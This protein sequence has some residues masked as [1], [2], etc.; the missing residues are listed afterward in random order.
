MF[1]HSECLFV[2]TQPFIYPHSPTPTLPLPSQIINGN[3]EYAKLR[4][5]R[6]D[7]AQP[8]AMVVE[9]KRKGKAVK[10]KG[11]AEGDVKLA[12]EVYRPMSVLWRLCSDRSLQMHKG[13]RV[14]VV[15]VNI[16]FSIIFLPKNY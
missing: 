1:F 12:Y 11:T 10:I 8:T 5:D 9:K 6:L 4:Q 16:I 3:E 13:T 7:A 2:S 15:R 14:G